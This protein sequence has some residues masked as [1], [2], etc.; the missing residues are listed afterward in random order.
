MLF[1]QDIRVSTTAFTKVFKYCNPMD[2][3][4]PI[5]T[6]ISSKR[7]IFQTSPA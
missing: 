5:E 6:N 4:I 3:S 7:P 1:L 2:L